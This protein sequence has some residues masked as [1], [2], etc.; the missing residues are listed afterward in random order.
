[1]EM[2]KRRKVLTEP[3]IRYMVKQIAQGNSKY[4]I[5]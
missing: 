2:S 3:E 5:F 4:L 1:M